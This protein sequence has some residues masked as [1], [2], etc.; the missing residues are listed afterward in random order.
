MNGESKPRKKST[1]KAKADGPR[2]VFKKPACKPDEEEHNKTDDDDD[3]MSP[4]P[5]DEAAASAAKT[6]PPAEGKTKGKAKAKAK[7]KAAAK[8][9]AKGRATR[10]PEGKRTEDTAGTLFGCCWVRAGESLLGLFVPG[11]AGDLHY[12]R[13]VQQNQRQWATDH[14]ILV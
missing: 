3:S 14:G 5:E 11:R 12:H 10:K 6:S 9:K 13:R 8:P 2:A 7:N 4:V 1:A